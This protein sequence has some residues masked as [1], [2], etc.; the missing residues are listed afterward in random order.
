MYF[1]TSD[2][3]KRR[4]AGKGQVKSEDSMDTCDTEPT[5]IMIKV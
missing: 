5:Y 1:I 3:M 4:P 2:E